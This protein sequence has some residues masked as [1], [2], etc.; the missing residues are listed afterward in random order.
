[1]LLSGSGWFKK[2]KS[3]IKYVL[4]T[5]ILTTQKPSVERAKASCSIFKNKN[6]QNKS[7]LFCKCMELISSVLKIKLKKVYLVI[8]LQNEVQKHKSSNN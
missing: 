3:V 8:L 6:S 1:M 7:E 5:S 4:K 2:I